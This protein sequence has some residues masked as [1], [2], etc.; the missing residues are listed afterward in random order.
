MSS[1]KKKLRSIFDINLKFDLI[2]LNRLTIKAEVNS[3]AMDTDL[4]TDAIVMGV[5]EN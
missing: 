4:K 3:C 1:V 2:E 5:E